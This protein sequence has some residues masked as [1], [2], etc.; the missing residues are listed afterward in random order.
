MAEASSRRLFRWGRGNVVLLPKRDGRPGQP[1]HHGAHPAYT[2]M[3]MEAADAAHRLL[4]LVDPSSL[5][6]EV[7][8]HASELVRR[9]AWAILGAW[10]APKLA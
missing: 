3:V 2:A 5:P 8:G 4:G 6:D 9:A 7:L 1:S 10:P